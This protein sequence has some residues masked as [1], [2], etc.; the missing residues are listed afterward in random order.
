MYYRCGTS[1]REK[2][3]RQRPIISGAWIFDHA[4][5]FHW[6]LHCSGVKYTWDSPD[7]NTGIGCYFLLQGIF[8]IQGSNSGL[9]L[10][11]QILYS[12]SHR[13][14]QDQA[15]ILERVAISFSKGS[16][17]PRNPTQISYISGRFFT[18]WAMRE[19]P[20]IYTCKWVCVKLVKSE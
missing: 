10:C 3:Q 11:R 6:P 17:Q 19:A 7:K 9:P 8:P 14:S 18:D 2:P 4:E 12:L 1:H 20:S 5:D 15:R 13:G 16:S